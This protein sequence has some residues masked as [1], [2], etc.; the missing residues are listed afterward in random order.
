MTVTI[1]TTAASDSLD[2]QRTV[3][4]SPLVSPAT[5][6]AQH[7]PDEVAAATVR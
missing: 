1:D 7:A 5:V 3:S 2:D 4:I 6:R